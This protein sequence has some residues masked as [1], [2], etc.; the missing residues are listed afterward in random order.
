IES[1]VN[2]SERYVSDRFLPDKAIDLLDEACACA[3]LANPAIDELYIVNK[4]IA[5]CSLELE[6]L[7]QEVENPD[8]ERIA[9][10]KGNLEKYKAQANELYEPAANNVVTHG[11]VAKVIELWTGIPAS[12]VEESDLKKLT[13]LEGEIKK[14]IIGQDHAAAL[15][16]AAVKRSRVR[17]SA[18]R[19][20]ASFIFVGPTG[21]GKTELVKVLSNQLFSTPETMIR[22]DM[23]EFME[24]HS[25]SRLIGAPPGYVGYDDAGQLTE[26]VRRKPYSVIL[27][28][29]IEK[30][31]PDVLNILLQILDDGRITD[32]QGRTVNFENTVIVMTSNA[33]SDRTDTLMGFGK[34][35]SD[36]AG[37]K[38]I[39][40]LEDFLRPEFLA[41]VDEVVVFSPLGKDSLEKIADLMLGE[42]KEAMALKEI[43]IKWDESVSKYLAEKSEGAKEGARKLRNTIRREIEDKIVNIIIEKGETGVEEISLTDKKEIVIESK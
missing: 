26:K 37:D 40:A 15:V 18:V 34:S 12:K 24:K 6:T 28:D 33:G 19:R 3:S 8:Y 31:H 5:D 29:E 36:A 16:A 7:E 20:P 27:F 38:A 39:K 42:L 21:V 1:I 17:T 10:V 9:N 43:D 35:V 30:A 2:L 11:D 13:N 32:A 22:L 25:V 14:H 41:R 23:S 4:K